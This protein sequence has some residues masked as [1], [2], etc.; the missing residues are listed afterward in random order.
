METNLC[1][2]FRR[3]PN[4]KIPKCLLCSDCRMPNS[5]GIDSFHRVCLSANRSDPERSL[6]ARLRPDRIS[7]GKSS[8]TAYCHGVRYPLHGQCIDGEAGT[9]GKRRLPKE[10]SPA[11][12]R[13]ER[14]P[15]D[16]TGQTKQPKPAIRQD[17]K[18]KAC[19]LSLANVAVIRN[20]RITEF[21][22]ISP[23]E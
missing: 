3:K 23:S 1:L 11:G 2:H 14:H 13:N 16:N 17:M 7:S 12:N 18:E 10:L 19:S 8:K 20:F 5:R 22:P 9:Q 15:D 21:P 6:R 4:R